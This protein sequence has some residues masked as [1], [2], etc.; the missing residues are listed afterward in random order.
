M[1]RSVSTLAIIVELVL[2]I[3]VIGWSARAQ[4]T[5]GTITGTVTDETGGVA[6]RSPGLPYSKSTR[7]LPIVTVTERRRQLRRAQLVSGTIS[8]RGRKCRLF[9]K[10]S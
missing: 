8:G 5:R 6:C 2:A 3:C 10:R 7:D 1:K 4:T 9:K